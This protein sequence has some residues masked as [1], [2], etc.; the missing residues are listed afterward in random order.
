VGSMLLA[1]LVGQDF[2]TWSRSIGESLMEINLSGA[3][4]SRSAGLVNGKQG[5]LP[6]I[7][8]D[9]VRFARHPRI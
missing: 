8:V 9:D 3:G 2:F 7:G 5:G 1:A 6:G 4:K